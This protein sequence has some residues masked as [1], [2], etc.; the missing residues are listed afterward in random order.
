MDPVSI[1]RC[2]FISIWYCN[3]V[4]VFNRYVML[5]HCGFNLHNG[6]RC[7]TFFVCAYLTSIYLFDE[8]FVFFLF[9]NC[10]IIIFTVEFW[11]P[12]CLFF[13]PD[14]SVLSD[15]WLAS[16]FLPVCSLFL[17]IS[18][19]MVFEFDSPVVLFIFL[20][21]LMQ[22]LVIVLFSGSLIFFSFIASILPL[23]PLS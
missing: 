14:T 11:E 16:Y 15:M 5:F 22:A 3:C 9:S 23:S 20:N 17:I 12:F 4:L 21:I 8:I 10:V 6:Y 18:V 1:S 7:W 13:I 2:I 19:E